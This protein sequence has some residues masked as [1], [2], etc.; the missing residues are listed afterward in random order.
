VASAE[1]DPELVRCA[2]T[3][4]RADVLR[5]FVHFTSADGAGKHCEQPNR[6]F[7][8]RVTLDWLDD[9]LD[10]KRRTFRCV[11]AELK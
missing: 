1:G 10:G 8:N 7:A 2:S 6:S 5:E 11:P 9:T 3:I 4:R